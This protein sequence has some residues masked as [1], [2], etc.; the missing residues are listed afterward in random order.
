MVLLK[1]GGTFKKWNLVGSLQVIG[2]IALEGD[3][4]TPDLLSLFHFLHE[5]SRFAA[6]HTPSHRPKSNRIDSS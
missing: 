2:A 4:R 3:S 6:L 1:S 5:V